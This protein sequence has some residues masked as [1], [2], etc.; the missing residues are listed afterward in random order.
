VLIQLRKE[1]LR[2]MFEEEEEEGG[3]M[4]LNSINIRERTT[5]SS[6]D[7]RPSNA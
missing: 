6:S 3:F 2:W 4:V 7:E 5:G 1:E